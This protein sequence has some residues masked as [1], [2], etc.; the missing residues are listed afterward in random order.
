MQDCCGGKQ[1]LK[2]GDGALL[3]DEAVRVD[4]KSGIV[5]APEPPHPPALLCFGGRQQLG[6][7]P[8]STLYQHVLLEAVTTCNL[9]RSKAIRKSARS[10]ARSRPN[11]PA[12][13]A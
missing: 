8:M 4:G 6:S 5:R 12:G 1:A 13:A 10:P 9:R 3:E 11:S 7:L 2:R